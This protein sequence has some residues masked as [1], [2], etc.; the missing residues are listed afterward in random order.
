M[1]SKV[2]TWWQP[3]ALRIG[4]ENREENRIERHATWLEIFYDLIFVA[5]IAEIAHN[6]NQ[7]VSP[8][9]FLRFIM[10]FTPI[11]WSWVS[12]T[13]YSTRFDTDDPLH[14]LL[15]GIQM[16]C[17]AML[18]VNVHDGLGKSSAGFAFSYALVRIF[19]VIEYQRALHHIAI[20]RKLTVRFVISFGIVG[21]IWLVSAFVPM[22]LRFV[23][24]FL[25]LI[26]D[27]A[28]PLLIEGLSVQ[29]APHTSHLPERFG[30]FII[31]VLGESILGVVNGV[32]QQQ[33]NILLILSL[34]CGVSIAFSLW[35]IYFDNLGGSAIESARAC[36]RR[37]WA[38]QLW[39]YMHLPLA[40][41]LTATGVGIE[42]VISKASSLILPETERWLICS[43]VATCLFALGVINF[44]GLIASNQP[45]R[46]KIR[47]GYRF[48]SAVLIIIL[49]IAG[50]TLSP[51][52]LIGLIAIVCAMQ[53]ILE[54]RD[55]IASS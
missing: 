18:A 27:F 53:I 44:T 17:L 50:T 41:G 51:V 42:K 26:V 30:L 16:F 31:I 8:S 32:V 11:W 33:W 55:S 14:R 35:W 40:I 4:E 9:G 19:N 25:A 24:W 15:T 1:T 6:L 34:A 43:A 37:L 5:V 28:T 2:K 20:A 22:P 45:R 48:G 12:S 23:L 46:C 13:L 47:I 52:K 3:P 29:F 54:L 7:D 39:L 21:A 10:L 38:Y 49:A 36:S